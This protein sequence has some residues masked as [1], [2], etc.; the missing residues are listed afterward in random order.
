M[1]EIAAENLAQIKGLLVKLNEEDYRQKL[2]ILS[3]ASIGQHIRHI[4]EFYLILFKGIDRGTISYDKRERNLVLETN[5][6]IAIQLVNDLVF[7]LKSIK[8]DV[9]LRFEA[10]YEGSTGVSISVGSSAFRELAYCVE[11]S[12]HHQAIIKSALVALEKQSLVDEYFGVAYSTI[13][14]RN[15]T[16]AQ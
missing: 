1:K 5:V 4:L 11:H 16:C 13:K 3:D 9:P 14:Y 6:D 8:N 12:I 15:N 7:K 2:D 10:D